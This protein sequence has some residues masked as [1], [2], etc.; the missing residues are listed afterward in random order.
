MSAT[1]KYVAVRKEQNVFDE[2]IYRVVTLDG[3]Y[4]CRSDIWG[5]KSACEIA[6]QIDANMAYEAEHGAGSLDRF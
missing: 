5:Y 6:S 2:P 1:W 3:G 4:T